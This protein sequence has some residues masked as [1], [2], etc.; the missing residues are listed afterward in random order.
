MSFLAP[1]ALAI[2][3]FASLGVVLLHLVARQRPAAYIFPTT[4][5][6][7]DRRTLVSHIR[8]VRKK[9]CIL[10]VKRCIMRLECRGHDV[11]CTSQRHYDQG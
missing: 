8:C 3:A 11:H 9:Q 10:T 4:R 2:G 6:V 5:F 1:W 7:P